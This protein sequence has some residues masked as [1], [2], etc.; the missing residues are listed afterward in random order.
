[1]RCHRLIGVSCNIQVNQ[2]A[3]SVQK[4]PE[5]LRPLCFLFLQVPRFL[6]WAPV[7]IFMNKYSY[8]ILVF[9]Y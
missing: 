4:N 1:M 8:R 9:T 2:E 7:N 5:V 6:R 3:L